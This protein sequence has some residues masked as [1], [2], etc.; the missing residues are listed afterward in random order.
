MRHVLQL[1]FLDTFLTILCFS[2]LGGLKQLLNSCFYCCALHFHSLQRMRAHWG[3]SE[4]PYTSQFNRKLV[5]NNTIVGLNRFL[6]SA[7]LCWV[8][9]LS[10]FTRFALNLAFVEILFCYAQLSYEPTAVS[11]C[12]SYTGLIL[13]TESTSWKWNRALLYLYKKNPCEQQ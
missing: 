5:E 8:R 4:K 3:G 10:L 6:F 2:I 13:G 12:C 11:C 7:Q 9:L 1:L